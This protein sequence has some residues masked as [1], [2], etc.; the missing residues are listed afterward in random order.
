MKTLAE[1]CRERGVSE[2]AGRRLFDQ[3]L[4][5]G[6]RMGLYRVVRPEDVAVLEKAFREKGLLQTSALQPVG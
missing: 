5:S 4:P 1:F 3:F 2:W 6:L